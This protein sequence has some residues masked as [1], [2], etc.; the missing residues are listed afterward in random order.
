M[1]DQAASAMER[2]TATVSG[3]PSATC[4]PSLF[5][6]GTQIQTPRVSSSRHGCRSRAASRR[7][8]WFTDSSQGGPILGI[9]HQPQVGEEVTDLLAAQEVAV[10]ADAV[11]EA[12]LQAGQ[13][14][15]PSLSVRPVEDG[16]L[17]RRADRA[18]ATSRR[19]SDDEGPG[20]GLR[21]PAALPRSRRV[22]CPQ[23]APTV[24]QRR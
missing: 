15:L 19:F 14:Q 17:P 7:Q 9:V 6:A 11:R 4:G 8:A 2:S 21:R 5:I 1:S 22:G 10:A 3:T 23:I 20:Q 18:F 13:L 16:A 24:P 12:R